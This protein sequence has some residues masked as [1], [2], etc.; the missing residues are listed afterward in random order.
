MVSDGEAASAAGQ[1]LLDPSS[2]DLERDAA[3]TALRLLVMQH[4]SQI[5]EGLDRSV[6]DLDRPAFRD[7]R[8]P[9]RTHEVRRALHG[10][11]PALA[12]TRTVLLDD[13]SIRPR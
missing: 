10:E 2:T 4:G 13:I 7:L 12:V 6:Q 11:A 5:L 1:I 8:G 3:G 9:A